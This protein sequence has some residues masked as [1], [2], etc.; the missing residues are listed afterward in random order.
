VKILL[1]T[2]TSNGALKMLVTKWILPVWDK[3]RRY[4]I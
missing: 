2:I 1:D 4:L 3:G